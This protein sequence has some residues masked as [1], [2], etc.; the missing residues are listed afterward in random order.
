MDRTHECALDSTAAS[1]AMIAPA[2]DVDLV[3]DW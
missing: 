3:W 2:L 1:G